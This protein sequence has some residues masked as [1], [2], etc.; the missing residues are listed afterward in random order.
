M[1]YN[2][3][4]I[5]SGTTIVLSNSIATTSGAIHLTGGSLVP[6]GDITLSSETNIDLQLKA[7]SSATHN[8][9]LSAKGSVYIKDTMKLPGF[10]VTIIVSYCI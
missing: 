4:S 6:G 2:S 9:T 1:T 7:D 10:D 5:T 8:F 3:I